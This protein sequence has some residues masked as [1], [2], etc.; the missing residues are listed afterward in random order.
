MLCPLVFILMI[1][2]Q[3]GNSES[4]DSVIA[5]IHLYGMKTLISLDCIFYSGL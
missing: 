5:K 3:L 4:E 1:L 2:S